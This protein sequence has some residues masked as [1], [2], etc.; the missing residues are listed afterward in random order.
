MIIALI[1]MFILLLVG[2]TVLTAALRATMGTAARRTEDRQLYYY[3]RSVLDTLD[4]TLQHGELGRT[5]RNSVVQEL[6]ASGG[7]AARLQP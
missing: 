6:L 1:I 3:A 4:E 2:V 7:E 5:L